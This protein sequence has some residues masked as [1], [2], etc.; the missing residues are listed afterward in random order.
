MS[1]SA[2]RMGSY[3]PIKYQIGGTDR[4]NTPMTLKIA[5][6]AIAGTYNCK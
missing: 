3:E 6:G 2:I 4:A 5:A 1:F